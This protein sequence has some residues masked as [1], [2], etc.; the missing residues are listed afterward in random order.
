MSWMRS[1]N[2]GLVDDAVLSICGALS[3]MGCVYYTEAT[4]STATKYVI[5]RKPIQAKIRVSDHASKSFEKSAKRS[6]TMEVDVDATGK[7]DRTWQ[8]AVEAIKKAVAA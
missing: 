1:R 2:Q 5:V 6:R 8:A 4:Q 3:D 7:S